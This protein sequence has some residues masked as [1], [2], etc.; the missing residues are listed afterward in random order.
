MHDEGVA[1]LD[2]KPDNILLGEGFEAKICDF[3]GSYMKGDKMVLG[4][5]TKNTRAPE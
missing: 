2:I 5:G 3:D 4:R 1:H